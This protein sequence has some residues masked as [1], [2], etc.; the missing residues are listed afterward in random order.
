[1]TEAKAKTESV[2]DFKIGPSFLAIVLNIFLAAIAFTYMYGQ[3]SKT[4]E[5]TTK[6][7]EKLSG[8]IDQI[9]EKQNEEQNSFRD[10]LVKLEV[11]V[12]NV[13]AALTGID[14]KLDHIAGNTKH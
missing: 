13:Q 7:T 9:S 12:S 2:F 3:Q 4:N 5:I 14:S 10:R 11:I 6:Y 1:M 8:K